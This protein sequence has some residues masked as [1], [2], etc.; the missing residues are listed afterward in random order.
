MVIKATGRG[1]Y[2]RTR[3]TANGFPRGYLTRTKQI[4]GFQTGDM[5]RAIV[6]KGKKAGTHVGR[7]AVRATGYFN[8][9]T[10]TR[11][12]QGISHRHCKIVQRGDGYSYQLSLSKGRSCV[13][14]M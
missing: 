9:E 3:L 8:I 1:S 7:I 13:S 10:P 4:K 6:P 14:A 12:I 5:A 2:Q 11:V